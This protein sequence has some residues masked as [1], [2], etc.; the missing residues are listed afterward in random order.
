MSAM[1]RLGSALLAILLAHGTWAAATMPCEGRAAVAPAPTAA[2]HAPMAHA[3]A[4]AAAAHAA[5]THEH[6]PPRDAAPHGTSCPMTMACAPM[7][8]PALAPALVI[9]GPVPP[10]PPAWRALWRDGIARA[11]E[12]PPPRVA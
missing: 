9:D 1:R 10:A 8:R 6:A 11:L 4:H 3:A 12:P 7:L 5:A 2:H